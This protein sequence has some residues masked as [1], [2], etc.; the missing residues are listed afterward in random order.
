MKRFVMLMLAGALCL[1]TTAAMADEMAKPGA[2]GKTVISGGEK[3]CCEKAT[4]AGMVS[5]MSTPDA[6]AEIGKPAP[7]FELKDV[8]GK[9][10]LLADNKGKV[11]VLSWYNPGCPFVV[12]HLKEGTFDGLRKQFP[13]DKVAFML[14]DSTKS[15][16]AADLKKSGEEYGLHVPVL[17]D[18]DGMVGH[19]YGAKTTPHVYVIDQHGKLAY[20][21][22]IDSDPTGTKVA[23]E[24]DHYAADAVKALLA[25]ETVKA[26]TTKPYGCSVKYAEKKTAGAGSAQEW[27]MACGG[28]C[29]GDK[30]GDKSGDKGDKDA[31]KDKSEKKEG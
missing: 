21:G 29:G 13:E 18:P 6:K 8:E 17:L 15:A 16:T 3:S 4:E 20:S 2:D 7:S 28:S 9:S 30:G 14:I 24:V 5:L 26:A 25:G 12:R 11:I 22:A 31:G 23:G 27:V 19:A 10:H 1:G